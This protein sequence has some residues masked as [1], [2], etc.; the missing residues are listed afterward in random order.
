[1]SDLSP[2]EAKKMLTQFL[3]ETQSKTFHTVKEVGEALRSTKDVNVANR[4]VEIA[5][6]DQV[7]GLDRILD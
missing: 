5:R 6:R 7:P 3:T 4:I 1:M 2:D